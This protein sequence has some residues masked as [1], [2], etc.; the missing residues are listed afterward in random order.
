VKANGKSWRGCVAGRIWLGGSGRVGLVLALMALAAGCAQ[1]PEPFASKGPDSEESRSSEQA[2]TEAEATG[3]ASVAAAAPATLPTVTVTLPPGG[4]VETTPIAANGTL[5]LK[6]RSSVKSTA[7][8]FLPLQNL[9]STS[10]DIGVGTTTAALTS[11]ASV[12]LRNN[13]RVQGNL[14][15]AGTLTKQSGA[16][17]TGTTTQRATL[18]APVTKTWT[19]PLASTPS[20][21]RTVP[22]H[23]SLTL[24]PGSYGKLAVLS[25]ATVTL[26]SGVYA[27]SDLQLEADSTLHLNIPST[28][29]PVVLY[30]DAFS[31]FRGKVTTTGPDAATK[32]LVVHRGTAKIRI[33][34]SAPMALIA[35]SA[36]VEL[37]TGGVT[38][39]GTVFAKGISL[40]PDVKMVYVPFA[41]WDW[42]EPVTPYVSCVFST[43]RGTYA[44]AFGYR[45]LSPNTVEVALGA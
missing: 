37:A 31:A 32:L 27:F 5:I 12:L 24:A 43:G 42:L 6:D 45:N 4:S 30:L 1:G 16:T 26:S 44:A 22:D 13:A 29:G 36:L 19:V 17:V 39:R 33:E 18:P 23:G 10:T 11:K 28:S 9:G 7:G 38:H 41:H 14:K 15:T 34:K 40:D 35:P 8:A 25:F 21:P 3:A 20:A 2:A